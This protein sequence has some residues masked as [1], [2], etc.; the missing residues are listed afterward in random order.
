MTTEIVQFKC[1]PYRLL[2]GEQEFKQ[3]CEGLDNLLNDRIEQKE[4]NYRQY[5]LE[6]RNQ[7][8]FS[9]AGFEYRKKRNGAL[10]T[11]VLRHNE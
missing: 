10:S 9:L 7:S 11:Y 3:P 6:V 5:G 2:L 8:M 4:N 1:P